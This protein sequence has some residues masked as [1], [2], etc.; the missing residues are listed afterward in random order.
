[1]SRTAR[2]NSAQ[3][4]DREHGSKRQRKRAARRRAAVEVKL[5][6]ADRLIERRRSQL[7][8]AMS[9]RASIAAKLARLAGPASEAVAPMAFCIKD[10]Q[11][12]AIG[13][14]HVITLANGRTAITGLCPSCGSK[15]VRLGAG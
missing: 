5:A 7:H 3:A 15:V 4:K 2:E 13:D 14:A 12:V 1:M 11:R 9:H 8:S 10:R 6:A